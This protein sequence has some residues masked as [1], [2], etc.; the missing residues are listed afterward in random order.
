[1]DARHE[2]HRAGHGGRRGLH[3]IVVDDR[4]P[5]DHGPFDGALESLLDDLADE[6]WKDAG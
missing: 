2:V 3:A 1:V 5:V 4:H 6:V